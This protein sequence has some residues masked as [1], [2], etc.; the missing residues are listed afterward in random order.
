MYHLQQ[1]VQTEFHSAGWGLKGLETS[2]SILCHGLCDSPV[3][4]EHLVRVPPSRS[5][6]AAASDLRKQWEKF[7]AVG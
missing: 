3:A 5:L 1:E 6:A 7:C 4:P 2:V